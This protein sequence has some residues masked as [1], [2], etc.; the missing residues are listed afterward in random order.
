MPCF[1]NLVCTLTFIFCKSISPCEHSTS[2]PGFRN[3]MCSLTFKLCGEDEPVSSVMPLHGFTVNSPHVTH[4]STATFIC[5]HFSCQMATVC[6]MY[7]SQLR[8]PPFLTCRTFTVLAASHM[9]VC[10]HRCCA[11]MAVVRKFYAVVL[12]CR[13]NKVGHLYYGKKERI[14]YTVWAYVLVASVI[15]FGRETPCLCDWHDML[16][17]LYASTALS[18]CTVLCILVS[19]ACRAYTWCHCCWAG[20]R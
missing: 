8:Q 17:L 14:F 15:T 12:V 1:G 7:Y 6:H 18:Q 13:L 20:V 16:L 10:L 9:H 3:L 5:G 19:T 4:K 2:V 11:C